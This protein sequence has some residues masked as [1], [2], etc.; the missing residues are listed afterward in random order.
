MPVRKKTSYYC[1]PAE[2]VY[3]TPVNVIIDKKKLLVIHFNLEDVEV[4]RRLN[5]FR[6]FIVQYVIGLQQSR[7]QWLLRELPH[8]FPVQ[9]ELPIAKF[10]HSSDQV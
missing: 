10:H 2:N 4:F 3:E 7:A 9:L 5:L 6:I 1:P 8:K